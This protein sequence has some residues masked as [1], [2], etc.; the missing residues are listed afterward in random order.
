MPDLCCRIP[1]ECYGFVSPKFTFKA[2]S[3]RSYSEWLTTVLSVPLDNIPASTGMLEPKTHH[4]LRY[5]PDKGQSPYFRWVL[6]LC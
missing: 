5:C 3:R 1:G 2:F 4:E 6:R